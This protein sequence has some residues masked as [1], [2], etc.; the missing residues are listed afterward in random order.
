MD[1]SNTTPGRVG[2]PPLLPSGLS[3][4]QHKLYRRIVEGSRSQSPGGDTL[5]HADGS[6]RGPFNAFL[7]NPGLGDAIQHVGIAIRYGT[8]LSGRIRELAVLQ[9]AAAARCNYEWISHLPTARQEGLND[10][11]L[12]ALANDRPVDN[13][14]PDEALAFDFV[15]SLLEQGDV[16]DA[17]LGA[18][19]GRLGIPAAV[20]LIFLVGYYQLLARSLKVWRVPLPEGA[21]EPF[22]D[23]RRE[24]AWE[25]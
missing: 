8:S 12:S 7:V 10:G 16:D 19:V 13:L 15:S 17:V 22:S 24:R 9:T 23:E 2:L 4:A 3:E 21:E 6:L 18:F 1:S 5:A 11:Q 20:E 25:A 14:A